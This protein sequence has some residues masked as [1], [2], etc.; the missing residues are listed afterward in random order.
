MRPAACVLA[1]GVLVFYLASDTVRVLYRDPH[2]LWGIAP[3]LLYL[4]LEVWWAARMGRMHEDP[5]WYAMRRP[6]TYVVLAAVLGLMLLA[7]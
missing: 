5:V 1:A 3:L 2:L 7:R 4:L 6:I